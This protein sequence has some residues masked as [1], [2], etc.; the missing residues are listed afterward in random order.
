MIM[1]Q[2]YFLRIAKEERKTGSQLKDSALIVTELI[3]LSISASNY[4]VFLIGIKIPKIKMA[5]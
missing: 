5:R 2:L 4:M 1:L 3:T